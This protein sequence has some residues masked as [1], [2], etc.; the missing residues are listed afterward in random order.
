MSLSGP[1]G[2]C[3]NMDQWG[4]IHSSP[5]SD[6]EE[7]RGKLWGKWKAKQIDNTVSKAEVFLVWPCWES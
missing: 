5:A 6:A 3:T 2:L 4:S 7:K 1:Q